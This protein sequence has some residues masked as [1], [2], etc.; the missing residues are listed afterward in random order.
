MNDI[1][2][3]TDS[4]LF[5]VAWRICDFA[6]SEMERRGYVWAFS[7]VPLL[8]A[9]DAAKRFVKLV[10]ILGFDGVSELNEAIREKMIGDMLG[11]AEDILR[12]DAE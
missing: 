1:N 5:D 10:D 8:V 7:L 12:G 11:Q 2:A 6:A 4:E 3:P 9:G